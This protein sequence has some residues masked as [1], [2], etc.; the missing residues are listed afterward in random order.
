MAEVKNAFIKSKMNKDLDARLIPQGEYRDAVNIQV[1]K[2]EGDDV[3]ALENVL[4]NHSVADFE[5]DSGVTGLSCIGYFVDEFNNII[6]LFFTDYTDDYLSST[7]T[8][9]PNANNFIYSYDIRTGVITKLVEG[10]FLNFSTNRPIIGVNL[11]EDFLFFTDNRN[12]PRKINVSK[13][14]EVADS[15]ITNGGGAATVS[16]S[17]QG[18]NYFNGVYT[19]TAITGNGSGLVVRVFAFGGGPGFITGV[20]IIDSGSGYQEG[21]TVGVDGS[22]GE[23]TITSIERYYTN[24]DNISVAKYYPYEAINVFKTSGYNSNTSGAQVATADV[25]GGVVNSKVIEVDNV[26]GTIEDGLGVLVTTTQEQ[27]F[28]YVVDVDGT[29]ITLNREVTLSDNLA[30]EFN[31]LETSMYDA[32]SVNLPNSG[33]SNPYYDSTFPGDPQ[34]LEDKF[35]RFS[36]RFKFDD[37]E[38]SLIAPFTQPCFIPKQDG[39]FLQGDD[40]QTYASTIVEFMENKV[41]KIDLQ[42]PL[43]CALSD[44]QKNFHIEEVDIIYKESDGLALQVVETLPIDD[45]RTRNATQGITSDYSF[46]EYSYLS[47]KPYKTLPE[48][49]ITRVYDKVPVKALGQEII[50][51][52]VVYS[53]FQTKHT[54]PSFLKY[55]VAAT[56]K[57]ST[58]DVSSTI[59]SAFSTVEYPNHSVKQNRNYQVGVV[60][61][62]RYGR[63]STVIL[64]ND[65]SPQTGSDFGAD[66]V[67]LPYRP[68]NDSL[69]FIGDSLKVLFNEVIS[70]DK[71]EA[72]L[73]PGL[74]DNDT[75]S[76]QYKPLGWYS[77][78]IVVKQLEQE[79]YNVYTAGALKGQPEDITV[80]LNTSFVT[81]INDNINKVPRDLSEVGPQ[82]KTFRSSIRLFGRVEN[83]VT[84]ASNTG[85]EQYIPTVEGLSFTTN[86]VED[87]FDLFDVLEQTQNQNKPIT[88]PANPYYAFYKA[89]SNPFVAEFITSQT[90]ADEFGVVNTNQ[91]GSF[92]YSKIQK[93][94]ILETAPT[95]SRLDLFYETSTAGLINDLNT[96]VASSTGEAY[97]ID[98]F[99]YNHTEANDPGDD[100]TSVF[101]FKDILG[102]DITTGI[103]VTM[104]VEDDLGSNRSNN[105]TLIDLTGGDFKIQ[106]GSIANGKPFDSY[107]YYGSNAG[108]VEAYTFTFTVDVNGSISTLTQRG[109]LT[110]VAPTNTSTPSSPISATT[111]QTV[112]IT[113]LSGTNG[114]SINNPSTFTYTQALTYSIPTQTN[115]GQFVIVGSTVENTDPNATGTVNFT[116]R[117]CDAGS[118][119]QLCTDVIY[120]V[121]F[122]ASSNFPSDFVTSGTI[123]DGEGTAIW[124]VDPSMSS[125]TAL[126]N[127]PSYL[128]G[129]SLN[130]LDG[131]SFPSAP[132][133]ANDLDVDICSSSTYI[134]QFYN[135]RR[136]EFTRS[137]QIAG[138]VFYLIV[139]GVN[140]RTTQDIKELNVRWGLHYRNN[141]VSNVWTDAEDIEGRA[142]GQSLYPSVAGT[143]RYDSVT[144]PVSNGLDS[145]GNTAYGQ[146]GLLISNVTTTG[147]VEGALVFAFRQGGEYRFLMGNLESR[148]NN[149]TATGAIWGAYHGNTS[150]TST[151]GSIDCNKNINLDIQAEYEFGDFNNPS[152]SWTGDGT[153]VY[154][155]QV[156]NNNVCSGF[157]TPTSTRYYA[158]EPF[159]KYVTT[160]YTDQALT[161]VA[162]EINND[163]EGFRYRRLDTIGGIAVSNPEFTKDGAYTADFANGTRTTYALACEF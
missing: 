22:N 110:N 3:G 85:N 109:V 130:N 101:K 156:A 155:Y 116:L 124:F 103:S 57:Y 139:R 30:L 146:T 144:S 68:T 111:G 98:N 12:Q 54:P 1:S 34:F 106:T 141:A 114:S 143:W 149:G 17:D 75:S 51:N 37:G 72:N 44:L 55:Q 125:T 118:P 61:S 86:V 64:S 129:Q 91:G 41:N 153:G 52:R 53:N 73:T 49:E 46:F 16:V 137:L 36:Y 90:A 102:Q 131:I 5:N 20:E 31:R 154:E 126:A 145:I 27:I 120:T 147:Q 56:D 88:D 39:Y 162:T 14:S 104:T 84:T 122:G 160:L 47:Q 8:Y 65:Q 82:D 7:P 117:V 6:Y 121:N 138:N 9:F 113:Q 26:S 28:A 128:G 4:G 134:G 13:A 136:G 10:A 161:N 45:I 11:L 43:P 2:S 42:I 40:Q 135:K 150:S 29:T 107:F 48:N 163:P 25:N 71:N 133:S 38:Y 93:L 83:N 77:Y 112:I 94:A 78:K 119:N 87:L 23:L 132:G 80:D 148:I 115:P 69:D 70:S 95:V 24:E 105:F 89:E 152:S 127:L 99:Q 60:L 66:T 92:P 123:V 100:I 97:L 33:P 62:D 159:A 142:I 79:Y 67:Y 32:T 158:A 21:D 140:T 35:V 81:L 157:F 58:T 96:A 15:I 18:S 76:S 59:F 50:S 151:G 74:Y 19:T 63:Q 108:Q